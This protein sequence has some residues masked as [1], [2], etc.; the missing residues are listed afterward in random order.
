MKQVILAA[1]IAVAMFMGVDANAQRGYNRQGIKE[2]QYNQHQRIKHGVRNGELT[3]GEARQLRMQQAK[4]KHY[5][6]MA[7]A[8]GRVTP[9]ER[10]MINRT[11]MN[12]S[13]NIYH[14][15]HNGRYRY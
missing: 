1:L 8:D 13:R 5:R 14:K 15:K 6:Q 12:A 3:R 11:Q 2:R 4:V 7:M 10:R 9:G